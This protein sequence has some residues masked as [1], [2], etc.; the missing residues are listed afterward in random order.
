MLLYQCSAVK[1]VMAPPQ[2]KS[3]KRDMGGKN[4]LK[5]VLNEAESRRPEGSTL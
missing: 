1:I 4:A 2:H 5:G 3:Q